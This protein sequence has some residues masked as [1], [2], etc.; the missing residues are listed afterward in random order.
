MGIRH[1]RSVVERWGIHEELSGARLHNDA[2]DVVRW[3]LLGRYLLLGH[4]AGAVKKCFCVRGR[5]NCLACINH[6][7]RVNLELVN[8]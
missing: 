4:P 2:V 5:I 6:R 1:Q 8:S 3:V 7:P